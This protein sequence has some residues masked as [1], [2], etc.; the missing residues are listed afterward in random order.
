M[1]PLVSVVIPTYN[2]A[3][4]LVEAIES[5]LAQTYPNIEIIVV[6]DGSTDD[7]R[8]VIG[9]YGDRVRYIF[10]LNSGLPGA[11]RN[12]G[13]RNAVGKYV[14]FLDSDDVMSR[15]KIETEVHFLE[16][17]PHVGMV[18][19][20]FSIFADGK[21]VCQSFTSVG[22]PR[23]IKWPKTCVG[24]HQYILAGQIC[25]CLALD[26]FVG[27]SSVV[28]RRSVFGRVGLFDESPAI[29][30]SEDVD[31]WFRIAEV[32]P[33]GYIDLPLDSYRVHNTNISSW[34]ERVIRAG[35]TVREKFIRSR[36]I[37]EQTR[38]ELRGRLGGFYLAL[39][40]AQLTED[41]RRDAASSLFESIR[42]R[43]VQ[44]LAYR[45]LAECL[46]PTRVRQALQRSYAS[47]KTAVRNGKG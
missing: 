4:F 18:I 23:F 10:Q 26:N 3:A 6:D 24:E 1:L 41:R 32:F 44:F 37:S 25:N 19:T 34:S 11:V 8:Q 30:P 9:R 17:N 7:T 20:D 47:L 13:I 21:T 2:R 27:T 28:A 15:E 33:C 40:S 39:A 42:R 36:V 38:R 29:H 14:A 5:V 12:V 31:L 46:L 16:G 43:P 45:M 35:I 22:H